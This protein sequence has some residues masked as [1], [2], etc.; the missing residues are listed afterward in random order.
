MSVHVVESVTKNSYD[1]AWS[2][3]EY[4]RMP[5]ESIGSI[6]FDTAPGESGFFRF[7]SDTVCYGQCPTGYTSKSP[8]VNSYNALKDVCV[9][10]RKVHI[11][12]DPK[13]VIDNMRGERY[14][15]MSFNRRKRRF[16]TIRSCKRFV[17][18]LWLTGSF[19]LALAF[20]GLP[21]RQSLVSSIR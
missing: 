20:T 3:A 5:H 1:V 2:L 18:V 11:P 8:G 4:F 12:F 16:E 7:G 19:F 9:E 10:G 17:T 13:Q 14:A 15:E 6:G 21:F